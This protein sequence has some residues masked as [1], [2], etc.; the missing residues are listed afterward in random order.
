M[1]QKVFL[2]TED[3]ER[4]LG[5]VGEIIEPDADDENPAIHALFL[6]LQDAVYE[7]AY[8]SSD[9]AVTFRIEVR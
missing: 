4:F 1:N 3:D 7:I 5:E 6:A 8:G 9:D 2:V